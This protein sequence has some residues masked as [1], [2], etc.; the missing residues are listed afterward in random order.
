MSIDMWCLHLYILAL[1]CILRISCIVIQI[2]AV[3]VAM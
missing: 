1:L 3:V 2:L